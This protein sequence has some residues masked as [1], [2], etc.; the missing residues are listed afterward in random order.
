MKNIIVY[1]SI[2]IAG[3]SLN[4]CYDLDTYPGSSLSESLFWKTEDH[5]KQAL[6]G[7]YTMMR[8]DACFG[9]HYFND[10]LGS[11][12]ITYDGGLLD[13]CTGTYSDRNGRIVSKWQTMYDGVQKANGVIRG[14]SGMSLNEEAKAEF[15]AEAKFLRALFYFNLL[16]FYGGVPYYDET[17]DLNADYANLKKPRSTADEIRSSIIND[18]NDAI[19]KLRVAWDVSNYGRAT[20]G[21]AYALRGKV[22]LYNKEWKNAIADFEE[23]V[24]NKSNNYGFALDP[25][26]ARIFKLYNGDKSPEMVFAVQNKG[27]AGNPYGMSLQA[28][29]GSYGG[30]GGNWASLTPSVELADMYEYPDGKPFDWEDIFPGYNTTPAENGERAAKRK[31]FLS[32]EMVSGAVV[33][34][35]NADTAKILDAY[36]NRD[37]R[38]MATLIVPYSHYLG[39]DA[40]QPK[41]MLF[42]LD[43]N[44]TGVVGAGTMVHN[45]SNYIIYFYRKFVVEGNLNGALTDRM[46]TPFE[47]PLIRYADVLL[48]L[49]EAYNEDGQLDKAVIELNKVRARESVQLPGLNSGA[50]WLAVTTKEQMAE[51]IRKERAVE[52]AGE[53]LRFSDLRRWGFAV[54]NEAI[55]VDGVNI[56]GEFLYQHKFTE[57]DMLWPIPAVEIEMNPAL[58]PN[59]GW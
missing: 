24:Y 21:A 12:A 51:R 27:G 20:K 11:I 42:A 50:A 36:K 3:I 30:F 43:E 58:T 44:K 29:M 46:D 52:F 26:Y 18:L 45:V 2:V 59:T 28:N 38:M 5:A 19:S 39:W 7:V 10:V 14:V 15:I 8:S 32:V 17:T 16:D 1:I 54:A 6:M 37:S 55:A 57:R 34:L 33:G 25:D 41:N 23:V 13:I 53:G 4:G 47:F 56:Y 22:Y 9:Q 40:N 31:E 49:A 48:M 35:R